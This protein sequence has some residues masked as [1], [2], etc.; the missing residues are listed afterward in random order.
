MELII[1]FL[2]GVFLL[3]ILIDLFIKLMM[4][5]IV[6]DAFSETDNSNS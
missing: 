3:Y 1:A 5:Q 2:G 4:Y 6:K